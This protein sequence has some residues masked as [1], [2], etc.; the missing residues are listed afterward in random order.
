M[1]EAT[2][3]TEKFTTGPDGTHQILGLPAGEYHLGVDHPDY[4]PASVHRMVQPDRAHEVVIELDRGGRLEGKVTD[5][6]GRPL[7]GAL[8]FLVSGQGAAGGPGLEAHA[9][10]SGEYRIP[11][12]PAGLF[13]LRVRHTGFRAGQRKDV[14][15]AGDGQ[16]FRIDIVLVEGRSITGRVVAED[17]MPIP[18]ASVIGNNEEISTCRTDEGGKFALQG[19][20][21]GP[22]SAFASAVGYGPTYLRN[23]APGA[24]NVEFRLSKAG[25]V[26]GRISAQPF[27]GRF[28]VRISRLEE[29]LGKYVPYSS[30]SYDGALGDDFHMTDLPV[31]RYRVEVEAPG[32]EAQDIPE[33]QVSAGQ[34]VSGVQIRLRKTS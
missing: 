30:R 28:T 31:G 5:A 12:I 21:D 2:H 34:I 18:G 14:A 16:E 10:A 17:G 23:L 25:E 22:V 19:L 9:E 15:F 27:P 13:D 7:E 26:L 1:Q 29:A 4:V 11:R 24:A 8:V 32:F 3:Q 33:L 20:G 6:T